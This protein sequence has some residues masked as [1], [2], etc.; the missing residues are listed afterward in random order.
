MQHRFNL[1]HLPPNIL[2]QHYPIALYMVAT[3]IGN[4]GDITLRAIH[5]LNLCDV[6]AC[7]HILHSKTLLQNL[8]VDLQNKQFISCHQ[9]NE[10]QVASQVL[11]ALQ[12]GKRVAYVSDAGTPGISDPGAKLVDYLTSANQTTLNSFEDASI[13][14]ENFDKKSKIKKDVNK[15]DTKNNTLFSIIPIGGISALSSLLSVAG[16]GFQPHL[17]IGFLQTGVQAKAQQLNQLSQLTSALVVYEAPH[18]IKETLTAIALEPNFQ[19]RQLIIGRELS[20]QFEQIIYIT[21]SKALLENLLNQHT[22][23]EKGEFCLAISA[24]LLQNNEALTMQQAISWLKELIV[25]MPLKVAC[26]LISQQL[27]VSKKDLYRIGLEL[28][29]LDD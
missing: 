15:Q 17:F 22:M 5:L 20:K 10:Q 19:G 11:Q 26:T 29:A 21:I 16:S 9:H 7:E 3:P 28:K 27:Q 6:I 1:N 4:L 14:T 8:G 2:G 25:H 18:R 12:E 13:C 23:P 24:P